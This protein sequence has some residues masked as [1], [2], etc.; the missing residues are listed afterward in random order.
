MKIYNSLTK[1]KEEITPM[2]PG[3][4]QMFV[5]GPTVYDR[6]HIGNAR[7]FTIF[8][9]LVKYLRYQDFDVTYIQNITDIEDRIIQRA[10]E[11]HKEYFSV[12]SEFSKL[13]LDD[14]AQLGNDAVSQYALATKYIPQIIRQVKRLIE[15]GHV[16][17]IK[18]D[19]WYF[20]LSTF[21]DYGKLSRRTSEQAEDAVSRIDENVNKRN[22]GDFCVWKISKPGEPIWESDL[23]NGRP[24][25]HIEDTAITESFFGPQYDIHGGAIDLMFPHHEAEIAQQESAS[26][27]VPF[28]KYWMHAGFLINRQNKMS[29]SKGNFATLR[30]VLDRYP[31]EAIRLYLLSAHYRSSLDF[32]YTLLDQSLAATERISDF[33]F[34]LQKA[35]GQHEPSADMAIQEASDAFIK[36]MEDDFN[37]P[38]AIA[39]VFSLIRILNPLISEGQLG[40][41]QADKAMDFLVTIRN[42][43]GIVPEAKANPL[44]PEI[45]MMVEQRNR[46]REEKDWERADIIRKD[47]ESKGFRVDDTIYGPV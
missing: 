37:T 32:D 40:K 42:I 7:T 36:A 8:D 39:A 12:S 11:Q 41:S 28:V 9:A 38:K 22:R 23:G 45:E 30:E 4:V 20:D 19:G 1:Q 5:C 33:T 13:F 25:W 18:D 21:P 26:G 35:D 14:M 3:K 24:G 16:Y 34:R 27:K 6:I 31:K 43:L 15:K 47:I 17:E 46:Y 10:N 44:P 2:H 29:K